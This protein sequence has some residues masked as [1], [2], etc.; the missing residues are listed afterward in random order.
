MRLSTNEIDTPIG[1][2]LAAVDED[3]ALVFLQFV[4]GTTRESLEDGLT[5]RGYE[6][7]PSRA[8]CR[9]VERQLRQYFKGAR[10]EFELELRPQGTSFQ[11]RV[12]KEL[13][14]VPYGET[15]SYAKLAKRAR[16]PKAVRAVGRCNALN[17]IV[18]V[19]PC[20]RVIGS[21]GKLTG[22]GGGLPVKEQ[23]LQLEGVETD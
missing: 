18:V 10:R 11:K 16:S 9:E 8:H 2:L 4:R 13:A 20:H 22:Y 15:V 23:L 6:V 5:A 17:P 7:K 12:W 1:G 3:R 21:N 19:L 14:K